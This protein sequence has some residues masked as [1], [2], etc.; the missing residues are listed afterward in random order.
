[1]IAV[2]LGTNSLIRPHVDWPCILGYSLALSD[3]GKILVVAAPEDNNYSG[4]IPTYRQ[5]ACKTICC[6]NTTRC[7]TDWSRLVR[8]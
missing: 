3:D 7:S 4:H 1:M 5:Q 2:Y 6:R 8:T